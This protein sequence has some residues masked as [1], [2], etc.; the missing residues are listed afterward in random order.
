M[1]FQNFTLEVDH[2]GIALVTWD[3]PKRSM[4]VITLATLDE[5]SDIVERVAGD[6]AIKGAVLASGKDTFSGG[7]DL[8]MLEQL[9]TDFAGMVASHGE[10]AAIA[11][12]YKESSRHSVLCRRRPGTT[13]P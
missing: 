6:T 12:F 7:A 4:N 5:L 13:R 11:H 3:M 9:S 8:S 1:T 2:D 10:H